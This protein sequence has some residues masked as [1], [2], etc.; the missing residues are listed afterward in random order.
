MVNSQ[1][2]KSAGVLGAF[3][4]VTA[5][6]SSL[7]ICFAAKFNI[8]RIILAVVF[9]VLCVVFVVFSFVGD[10]AAG[11]RTVFMGTAVGSLASFVTLISSSSS[12]HQTSSMLD[13]FVVY[14]IVAVTISSILCA[15]WPFLT[16][17]LLY[18]I[19][20]STSIDYAQESLL[21]ISVNGV[22]SVFVALFISLSGKPEVNDAFRKG[23]VISIAA[24]FI[25]FLANGAIG[26]MLESKS[27]PMASAYDS[28]PEPEEK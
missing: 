20:S 16:S 7:L 12:F 21:Y 9:A 6:V 15:M 1:T 17:K 8:F 19:I 14:F 27:A 4:F 22:V 13:K 3:G 2:L 24:W 18:V 25:S 23:F 5:L 11:R 28:T 26:W 10:G